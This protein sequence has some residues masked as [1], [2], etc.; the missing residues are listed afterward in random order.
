[1]ASISAVPAISRQPGVLPISWSALGL[2]LAADQLLLP[3]FHLGPL[4]F[5]P[6]YLICGLWL[7]LWLRQS[8]RQRPH[9]D[10]TTLFVLLGVIV[11][12]S[13]AGEIWLA[14]H[15]QV[16]DYSQTL[17]SVL[18]YVLTALA[19]GIGISAKSFKFQ[20]LVPLLIAASTLNIVFIV[21]KSSLPG[22]LAD[23]YYP[24]LA[25]ENLADFGV[26]DVSDLL[27]MTRPRGLFGNPNVSAFMINVIALFIYLGLRHRLM[28]PPQPIVGLAILVLPFLVALMLASRAEIAVAGLL[29]LLNLTVLLKQSGTVRR[30]RLALYVAILPVIG[31][32]GLMNVLGEES[33][34]QSVERAASI[35]DVVSN[36]SASSTETRE[37][38]SVSRPLITLQRMYGRF[39]FSP[40]F[41]A[42]FSATDGPP[43]EAGTEFFHNDWFRII[44]TSGLIGLIAL[45]LL[46]ARFVWP[47]G[48]PAVIPFV[49][50]ALV[51]TFLLNIPG[52]MFYFFMV[53]VTREKLRDQEGN[54]RA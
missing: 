36:A 38:D 26:S 28:P 24:P 31:G 7:A 5:K 19:F 22:W 50:P 47:L 3:M 40:I 20:W 45:M 35:I 33:L 14:A 52:Q 51:N 44:A 27:E 37:L 42:G 30:A 12:C 4:P 54:A 11:G 9:R 29:G 32:V 23:L 13:L 17:R 10:I 48:W 16:S 25:I 6:S 8:A 15:Y 43:F 34:T 1:M 21:L 41:G 2:F 53:A 46:I 49:L 39:Q 18:I